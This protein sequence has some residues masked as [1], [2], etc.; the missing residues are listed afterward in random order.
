MLYKMVYSE[1][2][3]DIA[4]FYNFSVHTLE[5]RLIVYAYEWL[6]YFESDL[7]ENNI[8]VLYRSRLV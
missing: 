5:N 8:D 2:A 7:C 1:T 4:R 3:R 6:E